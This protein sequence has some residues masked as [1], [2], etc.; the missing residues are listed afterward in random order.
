MVEIFTEY[1]QKST[2]T[3]LRCDF[4]VVVVVVGAVVDD[5]QES[6]LLDNYYT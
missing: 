6:L 1:N 5:V 3:L 2:Y 4:F